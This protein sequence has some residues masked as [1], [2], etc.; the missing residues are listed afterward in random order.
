[1]LDQIRPLTV[2]RRK[3]QK[4]RFSLNPAGMVQNWDVC[5]I[6]SRDVGFTAKGVLSPR[7]FLHSPISVN[8]E[9]DSISSPYPSLR[10]FFAKQSHVLEAFYGWEMRLL[11]RERRP[12]RNDGRIC[13]LLNLVKL[14]MG[15]LSVKIL[16]GVTAPRR[17][18]L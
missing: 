9:F 4:R 6:P 17:A 14:V 11:R 3:F 10:A 12:P 13:D 18:E 5:F 16:G 8:H 7:G 15:D 2:E 1:L